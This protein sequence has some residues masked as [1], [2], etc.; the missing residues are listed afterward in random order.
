MNITNIQVYAEGYYSGQTYEENVAI[1]TEVYELLK[2]QIKGISIYINN[3]DG[4]HSEVEA[5]IEID[6]YPE[7]QV[8]NMNWYIYGDSG[9]LFN[10]LYSIFENAGLSLETE[11]VLVNN[12]IATID[13][14]TDLTVTVRKSNV[15][16]VIE[17][18]KTL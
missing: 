6:H 13:S 5:D 3:L 10:C 12:Y 11:I 17:F 4:K 9:Y 15:D 18:C 1:R 7:E 14:Y 8:E 16:K 2:E